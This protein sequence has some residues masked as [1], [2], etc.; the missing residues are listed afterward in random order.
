MADKIAVMNH[1]VIEQF[2]TPQEIYDRP[3]TMFVADFIGSPPM[4]FLPFRGGLAKGATVGRDQ[5]ATVAVP[6]IA[7]GRAPA[8]MAL[9]VRPEHIRFDDAS[10]LRGAVFGAE[11]LGTTQ[12]VDGGDRARPVKARVPADDPVGPAR[13]SAWRSAASGCRCSTR[14]PAGAIR[15][16][17]HRRRRR[18]AD[19][20]AAQRHQALRRHAPRSTI[21]TLDIADG[22]F[23][24]LLGPT[25]AGKTTTLRLIAGLER[26]D[27][28]AIAIGGRDVDAARAGGA[29]RRPSSSSNI[30]SIRT[31]PSTTISPFRCARRPRR[32][33]EAE[34]DSARGAR[35]PSWCASSTSSTNRSTQLSGGE[36]QRVA[37]G[38]ALVRRPAVYLMDEPLSSLDAKL[39][40]ELRLELKRIQQELGATI[41][42]VTHDQIEAM[43]MANRIGVIAQGKLIQIGG[44]GH[45]RPGKHLTKPRRTVRARG[46]SVFP[47]GKCGFL[48]RS[49]GAHSPDRHRDPRDG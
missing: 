25:G 39:R 5:G 1:G 31:L 19:V 41:L 4:N 11:Y 9:G 47:S 43:T 27:E 45:H 32:V 29:R 35:S 26:P 12:I 49:T 22:E 8:S 33:P 38:R 46:H 17:L 34:I 30:R 2:G 10:K 18:M 23:V 3:A 13:R 16:A 20:V 44:P 14:H 37:I 42:Y 24:V 7:R 15:T 6:E 36:M 21:S 28:G 48:R 40:A